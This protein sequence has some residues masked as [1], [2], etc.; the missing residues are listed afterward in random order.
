MIDYDEDAM[1]ATT[2]F[3]VVCI[4]I[5]TFYVLYFIF[6]VHLPRLPRNQRHLGPF[7]ILILSYLVSTLAASSTFAIMNV[8]RI[9]ASFGVFHNLFEIALLSNLMV[10]QK[11]VT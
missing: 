2:V 10:R 3:S 6:F 7:N 11:S 5:S 8:G 9:W 4:A 1:N